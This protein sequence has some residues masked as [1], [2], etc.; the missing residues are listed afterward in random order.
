MAGGASTQVPQGLGWTLGGGTGTA[1]AGQ[2][3]PSGPNLA[4]LDVEVKALEKKVVKLEQQLDTQ[5]VRIGTTTFSSRFEAEAWM[6]VNCPASGGFIFFVDFHSLLALAFGGGVTMAE[7]LK[8]QETTVKLSFATV[9]E[10]IITASFQLEIPTFFGKASTVAT[11]NSAKVLPGLQSFATW[12]AG[13]GDHGLRYDMKNKVRVYAETWRSS[14]E[15]NLSSAALIVAQAM[16]HD[17]I[18]FVDKVSYWISEFYTDCKNK[19]A[20][21]KETWK[22]ISHTIREICSILHDARKAGRGYY[23]TPSERAACC[24]W[25]QL[26]AHR[27]MQVLTSRSLVSDPRL[28]HILNLH[29][30]DNAVMKSELN[31]VMDMIRGVQKDVTELKK[32]KAAVSTGRCVTTARSE[33]E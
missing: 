22:H 2:A 27:E 23:T 8:L 21:D 26:Q 33:E 1:S 28:S 13:D 11:S 4:A 12:D 19:G 15:F 7:I 29:L 14:A 18:A 32:K 6:K 17:A 25:G 5:A 16:M 30:R 24:F 20:D 3:P 9:E 31:K 10:A